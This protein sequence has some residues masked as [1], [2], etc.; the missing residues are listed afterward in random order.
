M[1]PWAALVVGFIAGAIY[2]FGSDALIS[3]RLDDAVDAIPVSSKLPRIPFNREN[4][5]LT[6]CLRDR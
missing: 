6:F 4:D 1:E 5:F 3:L 2:L